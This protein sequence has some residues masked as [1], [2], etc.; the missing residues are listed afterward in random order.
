M[1]VPT[2]RRRGLF[3]VLEG[4]DGSGKTSN[5]HVVADTLFR[6]NHGAQVM[7]TREPTMHLRTYISQYQPDSDALCELFVQDRQNH[8]DTLIEPLLQSGIH[9]VCD[10]YVMSTFAYQFGSMMTWTRIQELHDNYRVTLQP[11]LVLLFDVRPD[12]IRDRPGHEDVDGMM[13]W[14]AYTNYKQHH[15]KF[16]RNVLLIDASMSKTN[17]GKH[18][19]NAVQALADTYYN[20]QHQYEYQYHYDYKK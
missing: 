3:V 6:A 20:N 9:V 1:A 14:H 8:V 12:Q 13:H 4:I 19:V 15:A 11:D 16:G 17:V 2:P 5:M 18:V 10:R 7:L